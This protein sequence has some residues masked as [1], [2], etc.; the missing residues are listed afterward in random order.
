M[1]EPQARF[2]PS[3]WY[4][5]A[6]STILSVRLSTTKPQVWFCPSALNDW[7]SSTILSVD[8]VRLNHKD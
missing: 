5:W 8:F 6:T 7:T 3:A 2:C 4:D 1:T